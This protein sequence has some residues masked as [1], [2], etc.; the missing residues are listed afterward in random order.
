MLFAKPEAEPVP[1]KVIVEQSGRYLIGAIRLT[2]PGAM[3]PILEEMKAKT[4]ARP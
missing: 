4:R 2:D 3:K 1:G